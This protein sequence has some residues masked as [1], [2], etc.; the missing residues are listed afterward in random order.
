MQSQMCQIPVAVSWI[1]WSHFQDS[2]WTTQN[3]ATH[4]GPKKQ[5]WRE[6]ISI[7]YII[8]VKAWFGH[9]Q[10]SKSVIRTKH[11]EG[12]KLQCHKRPHYVY[13]N[14]LLKSY[15]TTQV[16]QL[17]KKELT[18]RTISFLFGFT[19]FDCCSFWADCWL[20]AN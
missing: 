5:R 9:I 16:M 1:P 19:S 11:K 14:I 8:L 18:L 7:I 20:H 15:S 2:C 13:S 6:D 3:S 4:Q 10:N 17:T 12:T